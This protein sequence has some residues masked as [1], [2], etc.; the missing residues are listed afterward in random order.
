MEDVV[1]R[2]IL[3]GFETAMSRADD[4]TTPKAI[5]EEIRRGFPACPL[6]DAQLEGVVHLLLGHYLAPSRPRSEAPRRQ[7]GKDAEP[8]PRGRSPSRPR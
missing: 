8:P 7:S 3:D 1:A 6:S 5:A 2:A 4:Q